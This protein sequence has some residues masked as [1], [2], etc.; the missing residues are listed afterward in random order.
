MNKLHKRPYLRADMNISNENKLL[1]CCARTRISEYTLNEIKSIVSLPLDWEEVLVSASRHGIAPLIYHNLKNIAGIPQQV[2]DQLKR[3]YYGNMARNMYLYAELRRILYGF[4]E[5]GLDVIALK[6]T[7][8][9]PSVYGDIALRPMGDIDLLV[10]KEDL[11]YAERIMSTL[12]YSTYMNG[13]SQEWYS[14]HHFHLPPYIAP[15]KSMVV[16]LCVHLFNHGYNKFLLRGLC[17]ISETIRY[18]GD[19]LNW[20]RFQDEVSGYGINK[21]VYSILYFVNKLY[22]VDSKLSEFLKSTESAIDSRIVSAIERQ[23][24]AEDRVS[25]NLPGPLIRFL[26]ADKFVD[27]MR[28]LIATIFPT[29]EVMSRWYSIPLSSKKLY[30]YYLA[31]PYRLFLKYRKSILEVSSIKKDSI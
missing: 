1:L 21:P 8:L 30:L 27:K 29:R 24:F 16:H 18:D 31:R 19:G 3:E 20:I 14:H 2:M 15:D 23:I 4:G 5:K 26:V 7:A 9:A 11:P 17:D 28:I 25:S 10:R 6:G 22:G 13:N 12:N